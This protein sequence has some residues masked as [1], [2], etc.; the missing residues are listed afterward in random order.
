[1][2][3]PPGN[4]LGGSQSPPGNRLAEESPVAKQAKPLAYIVRQAATARAYRLADLPDSIARRITVDPVSGCWIVGGY[5]DKDGY[6]RIGDRGAHRVVYELLEGPI[7]GGLTLDHVVALGCISRACCWPA[8]L[9]PVTSRTN[10]LRGRSFAAVNAA[11]TECDHGHPYDEANTYRWNGRRDCR[12]CGR[13]RVAA[14]KAR[15]DAKFTTTADLA[16]AA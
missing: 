4:A 8:H 3:K 6:A 7:P 10:T 14:Y 9:E 5:R 2:T 1:M 13:A 16:R 11:K 15:Q 12:A